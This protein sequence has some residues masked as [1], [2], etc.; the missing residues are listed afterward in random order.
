MT[1]GQRAM[2][3]AAIYP[4]R[5]KAGRGNPVLGSERKIVPLRS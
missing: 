3:M 1:A 5:E 2:A 4:E